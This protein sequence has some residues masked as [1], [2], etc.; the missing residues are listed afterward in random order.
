M[1]EKVWE[2][3]VWYPPHVL[4][5]LVSLWSASEVMRDMQ[6]IMVPLGNFVRAPCP[7]LIHQYCCYC[8]KWDSHFF[9]EANRKWTMV[10]NAAETTGLLYYPSWKSH[11]A[12]VNNLGFI[13]IFFYRYETYV[14]TSHLFY[15]IFISR[16]KFSLIF[17]LYFFHV[18]N[19]S[20]IC[21]VIFGFIFLNIYIPV[22]LFFYLILLNHFSNNARLKPFGWYT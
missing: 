5:S 11:G 18:S 6:S 21:F 10:V 15:S 22:C 4:R 13:G 20:Y 19:Q 12:T 16:L 1:W 14:I 17:L 8:K 3:M 7:T 9:K 2:Y